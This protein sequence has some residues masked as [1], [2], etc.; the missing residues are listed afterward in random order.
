MYKK[1]QLSMFMLMLTYA[2]M[3]VSIPT[4]GESPLKFDKTTREITVPVGKVTA[5][6]DV[7]G[8][9]I[10]VTVTDS[11][12][13]HQTR[14]ATIYVSEGNPSSDPPP[15]L[16]ELKGGQPIIASGSIQ[17]CYPCRTYP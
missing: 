4:F 10:N 9:V 1:L 8:L 3:L 2:I 17:L 5:V 7:D 6:Y 15:V 13:V 16:Y 14:E 11:S 12:G